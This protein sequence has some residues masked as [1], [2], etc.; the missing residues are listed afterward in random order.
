MSAM[1]LK[2]EVPA[3]LPDDPFVGTEYQALARLGAGGMGE[4]YA[5]FHARLRQKYA[6]K[7]LRPELAGDARL[8]DR[9]RLEAQALCRL[10]HEN[11][12]EVMGFE[13]TKSG[14]PFLVME[15]LEGRTLRDEL[16]LR[17]RLPISTALAYALDIA[18]ALQAVHA[19]GIVHRDIKPSNLFLHAPK[20]TRVVVKMLDFG[21]ARVLPGVSSHAPEPLVIPTRTGTVVG[22][23]PFMSP[24]AAAGQPIDI[25]SDIY[26]AGSVLYRMLA[27]RGPFDHIESTEELLDALISGEV[28]P[29]SRFLPRP[30]PFILEALVMQTLEKKPEKRFRDA[31][32]LAKTLVEIGMPLIEAERNGQLEFSQATPDTGVALTRRKAETL[33]PS[34]P[35]PY[36]ASPGNALPYEP[37]PSGTPPPPVG[38]RSRASPP[39]VA[40]AHPRS[41][42]PPIV[43][44]RPAPRIENAGSEPNAEK[45]S[46][47][48]RLS[49]SLIFFALFFGTASTI[50][51][52]SR[53][54]LR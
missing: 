40:G 28:T 2:G 26:S 3:A 10:H 13:H 4:V 50:V 8:V 41:I 15:L 38:A 39:P 17:T 51:A 29:P 49:K 12:V 53:V 1:D 16:K 22:T 46:E 6:A 30:L 37:S 32:E 23:P 11:I 45:P 27:G 48:G 20:N 25:R 35:S 9:M 54:F 31:A 52:A 5:V 44:A 24:E 33:P 42:P 47:W 18:N 34:A 21:V 19:L 14:L 43:A 36:E 7:L